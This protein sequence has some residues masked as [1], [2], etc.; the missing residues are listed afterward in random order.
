MYRACWAVIVS[1]RPARGHPGRQNR[2]G[3]KRRQIHAI[4]EP[5]TVRRRVPGLGQVLRSGR[6]G[7]VPIHPQPPAASRASPRSPA[8]GGSSAT[9]GDCP[10]PPDG[11]PGCRHSLADRSAESMI[12]RCNCLSDQPSA[13]SCTG[14]PIEQLGMTRPEPRV[15]K[16]LGVPTRPRPKWCCQTRLTIT[17]AA[18]GRSAPKWPGPF[19]IAP[20]PQRAADRRRPKEPP[21]IG[22]AQRGRACSD[23]RG[24][25]SAADSHRPLAQD[26][27]PPSR[28]GM[29]DVGPGQLAVL[30]PQ[31]VA[32]LE[33]EEFVGL[34]ERDP[35]QRFVARHEPAHAGCPRIGRSRFVGIDPGN[36]AGIGSATS[37]NEV[38]GVAKS[39]AT[40]GSG[41][42]PAAPPLRRWP[43]R[44]TLA[45]PGAALRRQ[46]ANTGSP[47][48]AERAKT[49]IQRRSIRSLSFCLL[50]IERSRCSSASRASSAASKYWAIRSGRRIVGRDRRPPLAEPLGQLALTADPIPSRTKELIAP[51]PAAGQFG[52]QSLPPGDEL[53][54]FLLRRDTA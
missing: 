16:S 19:A 35:R 51:P 43:V 52:Q 46:A 20:D 27:A 23:C 48:A 53:S 5:Y 45:S 1:C 29:V 39:S 24:R 37:R 42:L 47:T 3:G 10:D 17:R 18:N 22:R 9:T 8:A 33:R 14:E 15:P 7:P 34:V 44:Q 21:A 13:I 49:P 54:D 50:A 2:S 28:A 36:Q 25:R 6:P 31:F 11:R 4:D 32:I 12:R 26:H 40:R 30:A 41:W 38:G